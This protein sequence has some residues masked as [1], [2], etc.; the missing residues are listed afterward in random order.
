MTLLSAVLRPSNAKN[1]KFMALFL[2][3]PLYDWPFLHECTFE[4]HLFRSNLVLGS[5]SAITSSL[6]GFLIKKDASIC[7]NTRPRL[8]SQ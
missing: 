7:R 4:G 6:C 2:C 8:V 5:V 1:S 3:R